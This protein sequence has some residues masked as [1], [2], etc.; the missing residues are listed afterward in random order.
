MTRASVCDPSCN[1]VF[2]LRPS[3]RGEELEVALRD[4]GFWGRFHP[5][6]WP[7]ACVYATGT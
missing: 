5:L 4:L 2:L 3:I 1:S 7:L 6:V